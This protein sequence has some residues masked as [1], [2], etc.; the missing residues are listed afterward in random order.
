MYPEVQHDV[1]A[2]IVTTTGEGGSPARPGP[3]PREPRVPQGAQSLAAAPP[4]APVQLPLPA[5]PLPPG[6]AGTGIPKPPGGRAGRTPARDSPGRRCPEPTQPRWPPAAPTLPPAHPFP[7]VALSPRQLQQ[8]RA[9]F[10]PQ[11]A[12][13]GLHKRSPRGHVLRAETGG[14]PARKPPPTSHGRQRQRQRQENAPELVHSQGNP[15]QRFTSGMD[16]PE[17][18]ASPDAA[19]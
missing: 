10:H 1:R 3:A 19:G 6:K 18:G 12:G 4:H 14:D 5:P 13:P 16:R 7:P 11:R 17:S 8:D 15:R 9:A 2:Q